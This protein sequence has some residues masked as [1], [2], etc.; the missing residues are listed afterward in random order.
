[1]DIEELESAPV[2]PKAH[3]AP[4]IKKSIDRFGLVEIITLDERTQRI[5]SGH[6]R[7]DD[8]RDRKGKGEDPPADV[9]VKEGRWLAPV[10]RGWSSIDDAEATAAGI[11]LNQVGPAGGWELELLAPALQELEDLPGGLEALGFEHRDLDTILATIELDRKREEEPAPDPPPKSGPRK[12]PITKPGDLWI[13]GDHRLICGDCRDPEVAARVLAGAVI[14]LAFTSPP[15]AEQREYDEETSFVPIPPDEYVEWFAPVAGNVEEHLADDGS[16]CVNIKPPSADL[17]THLYV[18]D[19][20]IA[21]ARAWGWHFASEFCWERN[22]VP[23]KAIRRLKNQFE[24]IYQFTRGEWKFHAEN[25]RH[26]SPNAITPPGPG[27]SVGVDRRLRV[28]QGGA[29]GDLLGATADPNAVTMSKA[30]GI[31]GGPNVG[32]RRKNPQRGPSDQ[33]QGTNWQPGEAIGVGWAFPGNRLPTFSGSHEATGHS[34]AFPVG[35]PAWFAR[36][37][38]EEGDVLYDPFSG[39]GSTLLAAHTTGRIGF[40]V[41]LSPGYCDSALE[42]FQR[43][44]GIKPRLEGSRKVTD[45]SAG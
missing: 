10:V 1:M 35:L 4:L 24:P 21:H 20:V 11:A 27:G 6:G 2:N 13:L 19:L 17:D 16:W 33:V 26:A 9:R 31:P 14:N 12:N 40:G 38:T 36:L 22:G 5:I 7:R 44:T 39:S 42:R 30:Q 37:L 8:L 23:A 34:A 29:G 32:K 28:N 18:F 25:V 3:N 45:F 15:Y 43:H 41:E